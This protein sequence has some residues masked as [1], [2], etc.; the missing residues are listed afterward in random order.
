MNNLPT[1]RRWSP[2][3]KRDPFG[4]FVD[5]FFEDAFPS[6]LPAT[7]TWQK[8]PWTPLNV[9]ETE[10]AFLVS[11]EVPGMDEKDINVQL[12]GNQLVISGE[13]KLELEKKDKDWRTIECQYGSFQR[14]VTLPSNVRGDQVDAVYK[15]GVLTLTIPKIEPTPSTKVKIKAE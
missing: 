8:A 7:T 10:K 3:A 12:M 14:T 9:S 6:D 1:Q 13:K 4:A 11:L 5:R 2:F 15:K